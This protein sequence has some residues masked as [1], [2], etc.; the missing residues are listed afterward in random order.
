MLQIFDTALRSKTPL[1]TREQGCVRLYV[2]GPTVQDVPHLG[3]GRT[4]VTFDVVRRYLEWRGYSVNHVSNVT[5]VE[6]KIIAKAIA[7][8]LTEPE[9]ASRYEAIHRE[10]LQRLGVLPPHAVPHATEYIESMLNLIGDLVEAGHAYA[11]PGSGVYFSVPSFSEYGQLSGRTIE[12]LLESAG[13][14]VEVDAEKRSPL[15][16]ALWKAVKGDEPAWDSPWGPGRPGWHIECSAMALE[17]LGEGFDLHG[18]GSD[19]AFPHHENEIAQ[20]VAGGHEFARHW[21]HSAMLNIKGEKMSKSL[22]NFLTLAECIDLH[23]PR[24]LRLW[25]LQTHY[26]TQL[27]VSEGALAAANAALDGLDALARRARAA[28]VPTTVALSRPDTDTFRAAMDDDFN[29]SQA[30]A[31]IFDTARRANA[32]IDANDHELAASLLSTV[33]DLLGALGLTLDDGTSHAEDRDAERINAL[34]AERDSARA[35]R[36]FARADEI[37]DVLQAMGVQ[38]EDTPAGTIWRR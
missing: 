38:I 16:F 31:V 6:D 34:V 19:L 15:D 8:G 18:G 25:M 3:H 35:E 23:G 2:C 26:R 13:A 12:R 36:D 30:L 20:A 24:A 37:R 33:I 28:A 29:T 21:M 4:A 1:T 7:E 27:D 14:R 22:G 9:I 32:A 5:D 11:V 10:Q 17:L